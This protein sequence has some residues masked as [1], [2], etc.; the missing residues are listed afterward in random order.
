MSPAVVLVLTL[1][2]LGAV[3]PAASAQAASYSASLREA[4]RQLAVVAEDNVGYDR[5]AQ[6]GDWVDLD[7][8]CQSTRHEVLIAES[9]IAPTLSSSGCTVT[10]GRWVP[11][12]DDRT[13]TLASE[14][15]IDHV[16]P[17]AEAWGSGAQTWTQQRRVAFYNDLGFDD[18]LIAVAGAVN[19]SKSDRGPE[20]WLPPTNACRY[21]AAWTGVKVRWG[22]SADQAEQ[23]AMVEQ[24]DACPST[25]ITVELAAGTTEPGGTPT[26]P[27]VV[28]PAP[29]PVPDEPG[30]KRLAGA[31]RYATAAAIVQD[32]FPAGPVPVVFI[33]TGEA[34]ADALA[35]GPAADALG[36]PVLPV[37][38]AGLPAP[39]RAELTRLQPGRIVILGGS[40]AV[41]DAIARELD[42]FT[43]GTVTRLE[44]ANR[45]ATAARVATGTFTAPVPQVLIA[46]GAGF[47]DALAGGAVGATT[48]SPVL[49]VSRDALPAET[50]AALRQL[51]P[52]N[53]AV[54][55]GTGV[56]ADAVVAALRPFAVG[57]GVNRLSGEDRY[58]TAARLA[59]VF[60]PQTTSV[61]YLATGRNFPDALSGVPAAGRDAA[62]L[63]L[64]EPG[65]MPAA[66]KREIDRLRPT[67][68]VVLGGTSTV[69]SAAASSIVC[70][71]PAPPPTTPPPPTSPPPT[72][73]PARPADRD[74]GDFR[75]QAEA[76]AFFDRYFPYYGDVARLDADGDRIAC[77]SLP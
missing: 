75:T 53:I 35:G 64:V 56:V 65:C 66:T 9:Q 2:V 5:D 73:V 32:S 23:A 24:A 30:T 15:Q 10:S 34:F 52:R 72:T 6:F 67:T 43:T 48:S 51:Q 54:L 16:V 19:Q 36:G 61:V 25:T 74:C 57:G 27:P 50:A 68:V 33:A 76:Q 18:S 60:W 45:Y 21:L 31:D 12:Y 14:L 13:Y 22:L 11:F 38:R 28:G 71:A 4:V 39:I 8:D 41:S 26:P 29:P 20:Q 46:T 77:E 62:P 44:G 49:L 47:A 7:G 40:G 69:S 42:G 70:Q 58:A 63:L 55:G 59:Q 1:S 17:V 3:A 37:A